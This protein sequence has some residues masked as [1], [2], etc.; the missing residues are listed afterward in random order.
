MKKFRMMSVVFY[1]STLILVGSLISY[2]TNVEAASST[3]VYGVKV[4]CDS[5]YFNVYHDSIDDTLTINISATYYYS[6]SIVSG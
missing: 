4:T 1:L 6:G 3:T 2:P 5:P